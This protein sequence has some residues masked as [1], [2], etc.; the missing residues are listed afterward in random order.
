[1]KLCDYKILFIDSSLTIVHYTKRY[2]DETFFDSEVSGKVLF[3]TVLR[4][5]FSDEF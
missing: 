1:M 3:F 4:V 2:F 5:N